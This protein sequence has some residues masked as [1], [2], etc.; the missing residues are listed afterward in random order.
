MFDI[1]FRNCIGILIIFA[2]IEVFI[3]ERYKKKGDY[4]RLSGLVIVICNIAYLI[5]SIN[6]LILFIRWL[7]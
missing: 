7:F 6:I 5:A 4:K 3:T 1:S 2:M